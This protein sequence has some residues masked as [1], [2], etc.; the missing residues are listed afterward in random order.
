MFPKM[1]RDKKQTSTEKAYQ[2]LENGI[3]GVLGTISHTGYPYTVPVNYSVVNNK[4]YFH[5]AFE[6][7]KISN[8]KNNNKVSF[9]VI[10]RNEIIENEFTTDFES[11]I[12]FGTAK[13][14]EPSKELLMSLIEKYSL[15]FLKEGKEYVDKSYMT[16]QIV[17]ITIEHITGKERKQ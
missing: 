13:L 5:S 15:N 1:R 3:D 16:T 2:I 12:V 17:E 6:G 8:I 11:V 7:H 9:T 10:T 4:I 14:V